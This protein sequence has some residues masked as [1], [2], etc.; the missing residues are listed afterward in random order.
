MICNCCG[1]VDRE[2][3]RMRADS[4]CPVCHK[5]AGGARLYY[6]INVHILVDLVQQS[7]HSNAPVGPISGPQTSI[8]GPILFF[9]TLREA[10]LNHFLLTLLRA[11]KVPDSIIEKLLDD[12]RL[13][14]QKFKGL[15]SVAV[16]KSWNEVVIEVST[17]VGRDLQPISDLM[18]KMA[19]IRNKF[20]HE[21]TAWTATHEDATNCVNGMPALFT[22][23]TALHNIY[24]RPH[25]LEGTLGPT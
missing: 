16:G 7:Y 2:R 14:S 10:L 20:M 1:I 8:V 5:P 13:A 9:C 18:L 25:L 17:F 23:F 22:L 21:G 15:F 24:V 12:N 19:N 4:A 6:P 3:S 11:R